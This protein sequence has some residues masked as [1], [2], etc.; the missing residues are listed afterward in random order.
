MSGP[1]ELIRK[2]VGRME[3]GPRTLHRYS[4]PTSMCRRLRLGLGASSPE[5]CNC[6]LDALLAQARALTGDAPCLKP[7]HFYKEPSRA[8]RFSQSW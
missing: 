2:L 3:A 5:D 8:S 6:G 7:A 1:E 4:S